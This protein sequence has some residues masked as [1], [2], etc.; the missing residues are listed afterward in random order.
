LTIFDV[1]NPKD[2][3]GIG[4]F[5]MSVTFS[6]V[7]P[8]VYSVWNDNDASSSALSTTSIYSKTADG[9]TP[10][11]QAVIESSGGEDMGAV[12]VVPGIEVSARTVISGAAI[13]G[14]LTGSDAM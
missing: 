2:T 6:G 14:G 10:Q 7:L 4:S 3:L 13:S 1:L 9:E 12:S 8:S 5:D 11:L